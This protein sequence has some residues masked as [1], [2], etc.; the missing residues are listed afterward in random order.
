[1]TRFD[2][3]P[4]LRNLKDFQRATVDHVVERFFGPQPTRRFLVA[5]ETGLGKSHVARGVIARTLERLQDDESVDRIDIV[6]VCSNQDIAAQNLARLRVTPRE[7]ISLSTRLTLMARHS[8]RLAE[9]TADVG[10]PVNLVALTPGTS[11]HGSGWRT[12]TS[13]ERALLYL[14]L[15]GACSWDGWQRRAALRALQGTT[16]TRERFSTGVERLA[17]E[18]GEDIDKDIAAR[19]LQLAQV[20]G[21]VQRFG[22]LLDDIGRRDVLPPPLRERATALT[23][24]LR[25]ALARAGVETL[26]PD[27]IILDEFQR[28]RH[29]L[30]VE[31]GGESAELAHHLFRYGDARVLLLSATPYKPFTLAE[32]AADGEDHYRDFRQLLRFLCDEPGW[33]ENVTRALAARRR[34]LLHRGS[35]DAGSGGLRDLLLEVMCRTERPLEAQDQMLAEHLS[36]ADGIHPD[37]VRG[38]VALQK[39]AEAVGAPATIEYWKSAPY[40]LNFTDGY[41]IGERLRTVVSDSSFDLEAILRDAQLLNREKLARFQPIDLGNARLRRLAADTVE[42]GW[43]RL[44]WVPPSMPYHALADPFD[45]AAKERMT[46]QLVFSSWSATPTAVAGLLSYEVERRIVGD[47]L[48][49]NDP[50]IRRRVATRLDFR[51]DGNRP[52]SMSTLALFWPHP[53]LA[54]AC[55]PLEFAR[56]QPDEQLPHPTVLELGRRALLR[57]AGQHERSSGRQAGDVQAWEAVFQWPGALPAGNFDIHLATES[58]SGQV[59]DEDSTSGHS[60]LRMHVANAVHAASWAAASAPEAA[61]DDLTMIALHA[62]GN[63]AWRALGRLVRDRAAVTP[64]GHWRAAAVLASGMRSLFNRLESSL[65][66]DQ[67]YSEEVYWRAVLRYAAAGDLQAVLDEYLQHLTNEFGDTAIDDATLQRIATTAATALSLRS[68]DYQA[69]DPAKPD[70]PIRL[71]SRFALR[72]GG[73]RGNVDD[74]RQPEV[75]RAFNS[76]FWPFVLATTSVGQEGI[77]FHWWCSAVVHWNTPANPV[78]FEQREGRVHRFGGHAVRRNVA[79]AHRAAALRERGPDLWGNAYEAARQTSRELGD[80]S[81]YWVYRGPA[82]VERRIMPYLL[83]RDVRRL[84]TLR[85]DLVLYRLAFGQPRQEDMLELLRR[86]GLTGDEAAANVLSLTP[87]VRPGDGPSLE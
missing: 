37:D 69:F 59:A 73:R 38:Y 64:T 27:L 79:A 72:Y 21:A 54:A 68:V 12:G 1:M 85:R 87:P 16:R 74:A 66:L 13:E 23:G 20:S 29:L 70:E 84:E 76:P 9:A 71:L 57:E 44:L 11:F 18:L 5:D 42:R 2:A 7:P 10:K 24:E 86:A 58:L 32:D 35:G 53:G 3:T 61:A 19:F 60:G 33:N 41:Q 56:T 45:S 43:W 46:K 17:D 4:V 52:A 65:L 47:R 82:R 14:L 62:P 78:D 75:R 8:R 31:V 49:R 6:Y 55:D 36:H 39:V 63:V 22:E 83:S 34:A 81:P 67:L 26:E 51:M 25:A 77:D 30:D 15:S 50:Q 28:F 48:R 40:F 80:F